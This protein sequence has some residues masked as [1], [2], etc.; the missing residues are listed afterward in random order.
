IES[1]YAPSNYVVAGFKDEMPVVWQPPISLS[2]DDE[3]A[4]EL[5]IMSLG[6]EPDVAAI[7]NSSE[8][9]VIKKAIASVSG[10]GGAVP[11]AFKPYLQGDPAKGEAIFF[12]VN[13]KAPCAKCHTV[14][15]K[16]GKVGPE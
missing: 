2:A 16:G 5:Y 9:A 14:K 13:G 6:G 3:I 11:V 7:Q 10:G 12:D 4:I 15:G 8:F 1:H